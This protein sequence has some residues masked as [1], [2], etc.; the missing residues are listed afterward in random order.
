MKPREELTI[1]RNIAA[2]TEY[3][4]IALTA[5]AQT[6]L[7]EAIRSMPDKKHGICGRA[8]RLL[9]CY[10]E[11]TDQRLSLD[12]VRHPAFQDLI[13]GAIG[14]IYSAKFVNISFVSR[15]NLTDALLRVFA[16]A[17]KINPLVPPLRRPAISSVQLTFDVE[18]CVSFFEE[19][20]PKNDERIRIWNG[21]PTTN[22]A[23]VTHW[24]PLL[25]IYNRLG[26]KFCADLYE[27]CDLYFSGRRDVRVPCIKDLA[28]FISQYPGK[29]TV[30]HLQVRDFL[31][32]FWREF[33]EFYLVT[34]FDNGNGASL[35]TLVTRWNTHFISFFN[36][37]LVG[38]GIFPA[39]LSAFPHPEPRT[40]RGSKT[41]IR[42]TS[43]GLHVKTKLVTP[44]PLSVSDD[45]AF[46][47]LFKDIRD[48]FTAVVNW[49]EGKIADH[50]G[51]YCR[52][53][54]IED[55]GAIRVIQRLGSNAPGH[56][57]ISDR[58]NPDYLPNYAATFKHYGYLTGVDTDIAALYSDNL[59]K[60]AY[61]LAM[62][63]RHSLLPHCLILVANHPALTE[64]VLTS[65][66]LFDRNGRR[67]GFINGDSGSKLVGY[68]YRR[69]AKRAALEVVLNEKTTSV[70]E[71][72][73]ELTSPLREYLRQNRDDNWRY[74]M[75]GCGK[76]FEYPKKVAKLDVPL[77]A[78]KRPPF[79]RDFEEQ[80]LQYCGGRLDRARRIVEMLS[81]TSLRASA[82]VLVF[83]ETQSVEEMAKALGHA[84]YNA[85]LLS[86]YL[87]ESIIGYMQERWIRLF[88]TGIVVEAMKDSEFL[89][90]ASGFET[91]A[92]LDKF[93]THHVLKKIPLSVE[94]S[95]DVAGERTENG[96]M[97]GSELVFGVS[98]GI[99][100][101]LVSLQLAVE[102]ATRPVGVRALYWSEISK[103]LV[104]YIRTQ[105]G[106][107][108]DIQK[109]L[110]KACAAAKPSLV[111]AIVY[112]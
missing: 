10:L 9:E 64:S 39:T 69:G 71:Q 54:A 31:T 29:L 98:V 70:V 8:V 85:A 47:I 36:D 74:L 53:R 63:T 83:I 20:L 73:I 80:L 88:Q 93:L 90:E 51:R 6:L 58:A 59:V 104:A 95:D 37:Y 7:V 96:R 67:S 33:F 89:L 38:P 57:W 111:G 72:I 99:L 107:R 5:D 92:E 35:D 28:Q 19:D 102:S 14:A 103:R 101:A 78:T 62:P 27:A 17:S 84:E 21:W 56:K 18:V 68:K 12:G 66:E 4:L 91:M 55:R 106:A 97:L 23:D 34:N 75:L 65:L 112:E 87:P 25:G 44:V 32:K 81:L 86:R 15:Y 13:Q 52:R 30:E 22:K 49:A 77:E 3:P 48:D 94:E 79:L 109:Y 46:K 108:P 45:D 110:E 41:N 26:E 60:A 105:L 82:G 100:T 76:A 2:C 1:V 40:V 24:L 50:W 42:R 61:E 43:N 11:V 16:A